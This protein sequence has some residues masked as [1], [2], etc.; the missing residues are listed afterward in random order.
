MTKIVAARLW[1]WREL[2]KTD[3]EVDKY[4]ARRQVYH[5]GV[6]CR[7]LSEISLFVE[8][9]KFCFFFICTYNPD[10][11]QSHPWVMGPFGM[12]WPYIFVLEDKNW[13]YV[14]SRLVAFEMNLVCVF[15]W[16]R[17]SGNW[18]KWN[19]YD[20]GFSFCFSISVDIKNIVLCS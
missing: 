17:Q 2:K 1:E 4:W 19:Q 16:Y 6:A 7:M 3:W 10:N 13:V 20:K 9:T 14:Q 18:T 11:L 12:E 15:R 5:K 8:L